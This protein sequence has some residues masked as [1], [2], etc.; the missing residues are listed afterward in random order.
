[1]ILII[2]NYDSFVYTLAGYVRRLGYETEVMRN[3]A[4]TVPQVLDK[5]PEAII[6]SPGPSTPANAGICIDL[7][8]LCGAQIPILG[9][10]LGHQAIGEA[11]GG[12]T[13]RSEK[14][15]HGKAEP[16]EHEPSGIFENI[17]APITAGRYHSLVT[18]LLETS[19]LCVSAKSTNGDIMAM[20][21]KE[22]PV[23]GLQFHPESV[24]TPQGLDLMLNFLHIA[25]E[26]NQN[27]NR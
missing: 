4:I 19:E 5:G 25:K 13:I 12:K 18:E 26:W 8:K 17:D 22:H 3:D 14:P 21:H 9:I 6:L 10:C 2:D 1:M 23:Y 24:L 11:Y 15:M 7:I 27:H 20:H 16:I